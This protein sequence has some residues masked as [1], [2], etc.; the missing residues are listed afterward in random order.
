MTTLQ[1]PSLHQITAQDIAP[2]EAAFMPGWTDTWKEF[3]RSFYITLVNQPAQ[4]CPNPVETAVALV[5]GIAKDLGG[6]Q[7]YIASGLQK[8]AIDR[9]EQV[10][11]MLNQ[12][13]TYKQIADE[14]GITASRVRN[15][16]REERR[17]RRR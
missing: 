11:Q 16:E 5:Y 7:P 10:R 1:R 15:I 17:A 8:E 6:T 12:G 3:A 13:I 9:T 4:A 14:C 2:I